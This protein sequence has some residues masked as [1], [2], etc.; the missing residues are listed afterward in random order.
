MKNHAYQLSGVSGLECKTSLCRRHGK[1]SHR[2]LVKSGG[3]QKKKPTPKYGL[4]NASFV[5]VLAG[6][7]LVPIALGPCQTLRGNKRAGTATDD[8]NTSGIRPWS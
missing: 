4:S 6:G 3:P 5:K 1:N 8:V 2:T 7:P